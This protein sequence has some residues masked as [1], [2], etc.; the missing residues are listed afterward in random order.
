MA[1][2]LFPLETGAETSAFLFFAY[3]RVYGLIMSQHA[4]K[5]PKRLDESKKPGE[6]AGL[7]CA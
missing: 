2:E 6:H 5:R 1:Q 7:L 4:L 3:A